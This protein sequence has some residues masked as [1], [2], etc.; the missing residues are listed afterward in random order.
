MTMVRTILGPT[1]A[2]FLEWEE[3][4]GR[5]PMAPGGRQEW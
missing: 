4:L 3:V 2:R 1:W 5:I